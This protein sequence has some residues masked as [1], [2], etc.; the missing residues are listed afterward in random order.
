MPRARRRG[1]PTMNTEQARFNMVEQQIRTWEVLDPDVLDLLF[2]VRREDFVPPEYRNLAF[3]D[4][5]IPL[6][7]GAA[8][9]T[10]KI[11]ARVLQELAIRPGERV[12]EIGTGSG[13]FA[14]LL[15]GRGARVTRRARDARRRRRGRRRRARLRRRRRL[16]RHR[17]DRLDAIARRGV[18]RA[19]RT[20]RARVRDRRRR[21][22]DAGV[23]RALDRARRARRAHA[24][25]DGGGAA[26]QRTSAFALRVLISRLD[27]GAVAAWRDDPAREPPVLVDVREDWERAI[28]AIDGALA[29]PMQEV[30]RR[31][32]EL[33]R[34]RELVIVCHS[35]RRSAAVASWL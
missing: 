9:W 35:G 19:A 25:R 23:P 10:P 17:A 21:A 11:E 27:P 16:R 8:M 3:A 29:L 34:E 12:L 13:Y 33:P 24:V 28:C 30:A 26:R 32:G 14:A 18:L 7:R 31:V 20:R 22:G 4:V 2:R 1:E 5:E 15:A 6:G